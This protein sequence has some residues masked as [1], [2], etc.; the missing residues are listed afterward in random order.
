MPVPPYRS[1]FRP[2]ASGAI[3]GS[4]Q[5]S[6]FPATSTKQ[7][8]ASTKLET[9]LKA[10]RRTTTNDFDA[11]Y[12]D[13]SSGQFN[14]DPRRR[15]AFDYH[16]DIGAGYAL[17]HR[18]QRLHRRRR[19]HERHGTV[20]SG[21]GSTVQPG[22]RKLQPRLAGELHT[23]SLTTEPPPN[24]RRLAARGGRWRRASS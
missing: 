24:R 2:Y 5:S 23:K 17:R 19:S 10:Q 9:G 12:L 3:P 14:S 6:T 13:P 15:T 16:E 7:F 4:T 11:M 1:G 18:P 21:P 20:A 8:G 22:T